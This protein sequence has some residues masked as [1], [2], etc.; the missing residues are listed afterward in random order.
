MLIL[1]TAGLAVSVVAIAALFLK[2]KK[3]S[4]GQT[5]TQHTVMAANP[6]RVASAPSSVY[7]THRSKNRA[8]LPTPATSA[9]PD[10]AMIR[11]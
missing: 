4:H 11:R 1:S 7:D 9:P 6:Y 3:P 10:P 2:R 8:L 5:V